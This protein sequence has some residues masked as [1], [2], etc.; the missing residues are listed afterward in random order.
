MYEYVCAF[1]ILLKLSYKQPICRY[2]S[3]FEIGSIYCPVYLT[4][5]RICHKLYLISN[6]PQ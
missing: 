6:M 4:I 2:V 3:I 1:M 5:S